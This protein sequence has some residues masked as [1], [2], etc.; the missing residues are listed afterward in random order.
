MDV[1]NNK[2]S[3]FSSNNCLRFNKKANNIYKEKMFFSALQSQSM[4]KL[5]ISLSTKFHV[6]ISIYTYVFLRIFSALYAAKCLFAYYEIN[7][8]KLADS[9]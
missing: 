1:Y 8:I 3:I 4:E 2:T 9:R 6:S 7:T 5:L